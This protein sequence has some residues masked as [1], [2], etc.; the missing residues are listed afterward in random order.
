[1]AGTGR[2]HSSP[3]SR[4]GFRPA[5]PNTMIAVIVILAALVLLTVWD[6]AAEG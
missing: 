3:S 2:L 1:M 4:A 6:G 5:P